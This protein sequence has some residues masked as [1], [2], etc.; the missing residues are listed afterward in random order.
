MASNADRLNADALNG[1]EAQLRSS[2][3]T[4]QP[5]W[6]VSNLLQSDRQGTKKLLSEQNLSQFDQ[7]APQNENVTFT[8]PF[9]KPAKTENYT[10]PFGSPAT[11]AP[12]TELS[13]F[14]Q[15]QTT[16][17]G[18]TYN[19][20]YKSPLALPQAESNSPLATR[21]EPLRR[22]PTTM[23]ILNKPMTNL[24]FDDAKFVATDSAKRVGNWLGTFDSDDTA[25]AGFVVRYK[26]EILKQKFP[27][28]SST[29]AGIAAVPLAGAAGYMLKSDL[30]SI[31]KAD[32][33]GQK[34]YYAAASAVDTTALAGTIGTLF[35]RTRALAGTTAAL[36]FLARAGMGWTHNTFFPDPESNK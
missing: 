23:E 27:T 21:L 35:P 19:S 24:T 34:A 30:E 5:S 10:S 13:L 32:S 25:V 8:S 7:A 28:G 1:A 22:Q 3:E 11:G 14:A 26:S 15:P 2:G 6:D 20:P 17:S 31:G 36:S 9:A 33:V 29:I 18:E 16:P 4:N 12:R